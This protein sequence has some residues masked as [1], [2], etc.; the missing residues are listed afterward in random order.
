MGK[1]ENK[2]VGIMGG[3][4]DPIH[5]GHLI[6][7]EKAYEQFDLNKV[8][9]M[10][11]GNPPHKKNRKGLGSMEERIEMVRLAIKNNPHFEISLVE[12]MDEG[13]SYTNN[14]LDNLK[15]TNQNTE[16]FFIMGADSLFS[17]EKW[18]EPKEICKKCT[19]VVATRDDISI[20]KLDSQIIYLKEKFNAKIEKL[21]TY[22]IDI[23]SNS[24]RQLI[25]E[26]KT[27]KYYVPDLVI[28]YIEKKGIYKECEVGE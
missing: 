22:N 1:C 20:T 23:S 25:K 19:L 24:I 27:I 17:F 4:F 14:T 21:K 2:K 10:P 18:K 26:E 8:L 28:N 15:R 16:Y 12:S 6:L 13:Y 7:A 3:T 9:I 11:S 5:I